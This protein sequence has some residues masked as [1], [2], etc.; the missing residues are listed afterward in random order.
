MTSYLVGIKRH[1]VTLFEGGRVAGDEVI[2]HLIS[3]LRTSADFKEQDEEIRKLMQTASSLAEL[4]E[5]VKEAAGNGSIELLRR[6]IVPS[7]LSDL[8]RFQRIVGGAIE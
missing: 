7:T 2:S 3:E 1:A 4:L 5:C 8:Y 6:F